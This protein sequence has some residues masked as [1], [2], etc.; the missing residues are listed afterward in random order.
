M[1]NPNAKQPFTAKQLTLFILL[2]LA[3]LW[4]MTFITPQPKVYTTAEII[5][6]LHR[7][8]IEQTPGNRPVAK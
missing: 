6:N 1:K 5:E 7:A 4:A 3:F 8:A 2:L